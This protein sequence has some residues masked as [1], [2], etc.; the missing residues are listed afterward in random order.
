[1][2]QPLLI[3]ATKLP[4][5][6]SVGVP[7]VRVPPVMMKSLALG[8]LKVIV[9]NV[10]RD[11]TGVPSTPAT[12]IVR[13][14][15]VV[16]DTWLPKSSVGWDGSRHHRNETVRRSGWLIPRCNS[17]R[18]HILR[19]PAAKSEIPQISSQAGTA[20]VLLSGQQRSYD[21]RNSCRT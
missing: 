20:S 14:A 16:A 7:T 18:H 3:C 9:F 4:F 10:A 1:M 8:P 19:E 6:S 21:E 12:R 5:C 2:V 13:A 17:Y 15:L 11:P